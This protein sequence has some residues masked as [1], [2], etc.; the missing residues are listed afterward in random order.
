MIISLPTRQIDTEKR[1]LRKARCASSCKCDLQPGE[2]MAL[3]GSGY[4]CK[5][6]LV[7][8]IKLYADW[9]VCFHT[10]HYR[11]AHVV[12]ELTSNEIIDILDGESDVIQQE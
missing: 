4:I 12:P 6:C 5:S 7:K 9:V 3:A 8:S 1:N 2:G 11:P 10:G